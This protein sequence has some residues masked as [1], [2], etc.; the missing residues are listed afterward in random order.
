MT[1]DQFD[2]IG[3]I[4]GHATELKQLFELLGY[5]NEN[6]CY[7]HPSRKVLFVGDYI[8]RGP[9]IREV[10]HIV[11]SMTD[12]GQAVA[13]MGNHEYNC[14]CFH[15][16]DSN[17]KYLREHSAK[18][19]NQHQATLYQFENYQEEWSKYLEWMWT[20]PLWH[21]NKNF[22]AVHACWSESII[23]NLIHRLQGRHL[24]KESLI[25]SSRKSSSLYEWIEVTLK[26]KE[27][28]LPEGVHFLDKDKHPRK[29][30]RIKWWMSPENTSYASLKVNP[31]YD[32]PDILVD[33]SHPILSDIYDKEAPPIFFGHYWLKG[34]PSIYESNVCCLDYSVAKKGKLVAYRYYGEKVLNN[35]H[36][37]WNK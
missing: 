1:E 33:P 13:L 30:V 31:E 27:L 32:V 12:Q 3:D 9:E 21:E 24:T 18:N 7:Q 8:D 34:T 28:P 26:G 22:R 20:L 36:L 19:T 29:S 11:K 17:G 10:L 14:L 4:H 6:G 2:I 37:V 16:K 15:T 5:T 23:Q 35:D 25:E